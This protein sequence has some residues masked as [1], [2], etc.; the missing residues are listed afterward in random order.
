MD[1]KAKLINLV[2]P[3]YRFGQNDIEYALE[4]SKR[5]VGG[6]CLFW[7]TPGSVYELTSTVKERFGTDMLFCADYEEGA[8]RWVNG[9]TELPSN[10]AIGASGLEALAYEKARITAAEA[11]AMGVDWV[12][13]PVVDLADSAENPI[14]NIRS[15]GDRTELVSR[16]AGAY[17]RGLTDGGVLNSLKHFPG[18]GATET[19]SHM[20]LPVLRR[21]LAQLKATEL[22]PYADNLSRADSVMIGH[23]VFPD[24]DAENP[25]SL[26]PKMINGLLRRDMGFEKCVLTDGLSM[27]AIGDENEAALKALAAGADILLVPDNPTRLCDFLSKAFDEG[28][29]KHAD[30]ERAYAHLQQVRRRA[31]EIRRQALPLE[32]VGC[33]E[34]HAFCRRSAAQCLSWYQREGFKSFEDGETVA[35]I[36]AGT[37]DFTAI[38]G[39]RFVDALEQHGVRVVPWSESVSHLRL[40]VASLSRPQAFSGKINLEDTEV[41][42]ITRACK[43]KMTMV[44]FGS[45]FV[46]GR[47]AGKIAGGLC[48]FSAIGEFQQAAAAVLCGKAEAAGKAPAGGL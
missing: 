46:F 40:L 32:T 24:I 15:F 22:V 48:T 2:M 20:A 6:F 9:S 1:L 29:I 14:V 37:Q 47:F 41:A 27:K 39:R 25:A 38:K 3:A 30:I 21:S 42:R 13:A 8:G 5:G 23:L 7:G 28:R 4:L 17:S 33:D 11:L 34:H 45:P 18:H 10:M 19:D 31:A 35:Y 12:F 43:G 26:S 44:S 16:L 36:E